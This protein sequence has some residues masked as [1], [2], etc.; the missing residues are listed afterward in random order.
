VKA[1]LDA[2]TD[3]KAYAAFGVLEWQM[4][5]PDKIVPPATTPKA[6]ASPTCAK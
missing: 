1:V 5:S 6:Y 2:S 4:L 3:G